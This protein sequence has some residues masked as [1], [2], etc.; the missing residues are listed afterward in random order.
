LSKE[1]LAAASQVSKTWKGFSEAFISNQLCSLLLHREVL[2]FSH[3]V[4]YDIQKWNITRLTKQTTFTITPLVV[5]KRNTFID[6]NYQILG[7]SDAVIFFYESRG[8]LP[9]VVSH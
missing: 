9:I 5:R 4:C 2:K 3:E 1:D 6:D 7:S 8:K